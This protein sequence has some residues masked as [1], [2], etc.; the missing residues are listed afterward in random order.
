MKIVADENIPHVK[1]LFSKFAEIVTCGGREI[2]SDMLTDIDV[3][4]VRS[5]TNV[6]EKLLEKSTSY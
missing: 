3:L 1:E 4:F 6:G 2:T 5:V